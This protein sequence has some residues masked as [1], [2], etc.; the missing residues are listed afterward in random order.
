MYRQMPPGMLACHVSPRMG[1]KGLRH[2]STEWCSPATIHATSS[3]MRSS[4]SVCAAALQCWRC[5]WCVVC[6]TAVRGG[7]VSAGEAGHTGLAKQAA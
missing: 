4:G 6:A 7:V 5:V 2:A 3:F 1:L